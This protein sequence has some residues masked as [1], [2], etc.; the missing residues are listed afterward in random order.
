MRRGVRRFGLFK[1]IDRGDAS[2][3]SSNTILGTPDYMAPEA[4][5]EPTIVDPRTDLYAVGAMAYFLLSGETVFDGSTVVEVCGKHLYERPQPLVER[6]ARVPPALEE[7]VMA[8]LAKKPEERPASA[9]ALADMLRACSLPE[10]TRADA[11]AW[12]ERPEAKARR[13]GVR[14]VKRSP[15][16]SGVTVAV[17]ME[18]RGAA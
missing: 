17:T 3:T 10:W 14:A 9:A 11:R 13:S 18:G 1:E 16:A 7:V 6:G 15:V 4:I 8:C 12:W 5:I 2:V